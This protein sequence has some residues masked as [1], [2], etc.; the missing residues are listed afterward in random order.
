MI[1]KKLV[2]FLTCLFIVGTAFSQQNHLKFKGVP[3]DG[4]LQSYTNAMKQA[5]FNYKGS[6]DGVSILSG[7]FAGYKGCII[8]VS[9]LKNCDVV[10]RIS[11]LFPERETWS[12]LLNDYE[13][14]KAML[15]EKYGKPSDSQEKF[16]GYV[17][18]YDNSLVMHALKEDEYVWYTTFTTELGDI[19]LSIIA[20]TKYLTGCVRLSYFDK[21]NSEKVRSSAIDDL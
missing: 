16:T 20:G 5:G 21:A 11:V 10:C 14:L 1:M 7:D 19:E 17:G 3:I 4:T 2:F 12:S 15:T 8:G 9:T 6:Q 18:D 13:T